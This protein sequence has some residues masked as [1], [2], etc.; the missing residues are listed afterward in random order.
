MN[1]GYRRMKVIIES[2]VNK[3][4]RHKTEELKETWEIEKEGAV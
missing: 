1:M 4:L 3:S 2:T